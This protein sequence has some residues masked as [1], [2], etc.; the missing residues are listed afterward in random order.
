M[1]KTT[2]KRTQK[3]TQLLTSYQTIPLSKANEMFAKSIAKPKDGENDSSVA[4]F[5]QIMAQVTSNAGSFSLSDVIKASRSYD[6]EDR[7]D[8][9]TLAGLFKQWT[10]KMTQLGKLETIIG[11]MDYPVYILS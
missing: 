9:L 10:E 6:L 8:A 4:L 3:V 7:L 1:T 2:T 5:L 11:C